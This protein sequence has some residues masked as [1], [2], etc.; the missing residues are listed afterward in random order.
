MRSSTSALDCA[1]S[2]ATK[3]RVQRPGPA[4]RRAP[5]PPRMA[6]R[7]S[8]SV[9]MPTRRPASSTTSAIRPA[10][11]STASSPSRIVASFRT[12]QRAS[13]SVTRR[14]WRG[15]GRRAPSRRPATS[16]DDDR[17]HADGGARPDAD[18]VP[19]ARAEPDRTCRPRSRSPPPTTAPGARWL[20]APTRT[21]C[22][23]ITPELTMACGPTTAPAFTTAPGQHDRAGLDAGAGRDPGGGVDDDGPAAPSGPMAA[24]TRRLASG[25]APNPTDEPR[26]VAGPGGVEPG[27]QGR[28]I[29]LVDR[30]STTRHADGSAAGGLGDDAGVLAAAQDDQ[31]AGRHAGTR[32]GGLARGPGRSPCGDDMRD[33]CPGTTVR[34]ARPAV[35]ASALRKRRRRA[36]GGAR[37]RPRPDRPGRR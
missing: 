4:G 16:R 18:V 37:R 22:S 28:I 10:P 32:I 30:G 15:P 19:D 20:N 13:S 12:M 27:S 3:S 23:T 33:A 8:P 29:G 14:I 26:A 7:R 17:A 34:R 21:S 5:A 35:A 1:G 31:R 6:R 36:R 24:T 25:G 2:T 9:A 11:R